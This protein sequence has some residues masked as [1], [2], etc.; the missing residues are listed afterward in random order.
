[1]KIYFNRKPVYGPWGGGT[2]V[3]RACIDAFKR[4]GHDVVHE[5]DPTVDVIMCWDPRPGDEKGLLGYDG[6]LNHA[7]STIRDHKKRQFIVQ[8]VGDIGTHGKPELTR[9]VV[10]SIARSDTCIFPSLWAM[11]CM[12]YAL[13]LNDYRLDKQ[14]H[15]VPNAP[16]RSFYQARNIKDVLPERLSFVTHHWSTNPKKG[17]SFYE[18]LKAWC[19]MNGHT[20]TY[21][22]RVPEGSTLTAQGPMS[23]NELA[24]ELPKHHVYVTASHVEAGANHVLE[25]MAAGLPVVFHQAGGSIPEYCGQY[26]ASFDGTIE[27]F[28]KALELLRVQYPKIKRSLKKYR[29]TTDDVAGRYVT[30]VE[31]LINGR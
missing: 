14:W 31:G 12:Q 16:L 15:V 26:G 30:I 1:M 17:F 18:E 11:N 8:R 2:K 27:G 13:E 7:R 25:A 19:A 24:V 9:L 21:I 5:L 6:C 29:E 28:N 23:E 4:A 3:L 20:F 10:A 22:G